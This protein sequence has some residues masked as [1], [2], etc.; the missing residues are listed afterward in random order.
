MSNTPAHTIGGGPPRHQSVQATRLIHERYG[1]IMEFVYSKLA[2]E[3]LVNSR[4]AGEW[5]YLR[6]S[7][8]EMPEERATRALIELGL[9]IRLVDDDESKELS[10][11]V[12]S[13]FGEVVNFDGSRE[14]LLIREVANKVIHAERYGWNVS[15]TADPIVVCLPT[16]H[17]QARGY[18]WASASINL[19]N[20]GSFCGMLMG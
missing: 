4:F 5:K 2:L 1:T 16:K 10:N 17:Q 9:Y 8:L 6:R 7:L 18:K 13:P 20:L 12:R 15:A 3:Q 11:Y 14:P 19:V